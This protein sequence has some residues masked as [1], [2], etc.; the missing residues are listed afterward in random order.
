[1]KA[2]QGVISLGLSARQAAKLNVRQ[3]LS[4]L[5]VSAGS[6][7]D[8]RAVERFSN[9]IADELNVKTVSLH[10]GIAP[11]LAVSTR[12]NKK[13]AAGKLGARFKE[14]E[15]TIGKMT[16]AQL[17]ARPLIVAGVELDPADV[18]REYSGSEGW[19]GVAEGGTQVAICTT[20]T[21]SLRLEGLARDIV[22]Q[23]QSARK[24][25]KLDLLDKIA[26]H[27]ATPSAELAPAIATHRDTIATAV[28]ATQWSDAPLTGAGVH[29]AQVKIDGQVLDISLRKV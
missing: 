26:L 23:V 14:A 18:V 13:T 22:R 7:G 25:A 11:L 5:V 2:V 28:Q 6:D 16:A 19:K 9:L 4:E 10:S 17:D 24:D 20:I 8:R 3:P 12:L 1:M 29:I 15:A 21:D 27:L